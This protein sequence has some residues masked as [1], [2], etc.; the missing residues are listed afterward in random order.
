MLLTIVVPVLN[1]SSAA[2]RLLAGIP[3]DPR[4]EVILA[5]GGHDVH[6]DG[7]GARRTDVRVIRG[8]AGRAAQMNAGAAA[9]RGEWLAFVHADSLLPA[10]WLDM[11]EQGIAGARGGWFQFALDDPSWQA[12]AIE[13]GVRWRVR[14]LRLP[15]GDQGIF[16]RRDVFAAL[17]GYRALPIMEDVDF[18]RRLVASGP[19]VELPMAIRTS[20]RRWRR[21]GW[22]ARSVRNLALITLYFAGVNPARIARFYGGAHR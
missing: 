11:F 21:D 17:G 22:L 10:R 14:L 3:E 16:V 9:A 1:D 15:Y 7:L 18:V 12:R 5:D 4:V 13:R 6:L 19:V 20:A 2:A 8:D